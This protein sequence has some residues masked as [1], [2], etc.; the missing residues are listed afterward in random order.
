[1]GRLASISLLRCAADRGIGSAEDRAG[2]PSRERRGRPHRVAWIAQGVGEHEIGLI[3]PRNS[4]CEPLD[5]LGCLLASQASRTNVG[6]M[7]VRRLRRSWAPPDSMWCAGALVVGDSTGLSQARRTSAPSH[8]PRGRS[9]QGRAI[10][11]AG[12]RSEA[13]AYSGPIGSSA[14]PLRSREAS[15]GTEPHLAG[16]HSGRRARAATL[17]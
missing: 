3:L 10:R 14:V 2:S 12:I 5:S 6:T 11:Q 4:G 16:R 7:I 13:T 1:M 15:Q 17:R 8:R 9:R